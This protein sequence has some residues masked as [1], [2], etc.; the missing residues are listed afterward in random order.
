MSDARSIL[1]LGI[2][3]G[4]TKTYGVVLDGADK[5]VAR[6]SSP[7]Q[8]SA[9]GVQASV[10]GVARALAVELGIDITGFASVGIGIPG[11]V[12]TCTGEVVSAVNLG[13]DRMP[14]A[15]AMA[16]VFQVPVCID[17]DMKVALRGAGLL[18][19]TDSLVY[20]NIG[21]GVASAAME[22]GRVVRGTENIAGEIGHIIYEPGGPLCLCGQQGCLE[23]VLGGR[24]LVPR[25]AEAGVE[26]A[27]L[28][29]MPKH[30]EYARCVGALAW[31]ISVLYLMYDPSVIALGGGVVGAASWL[32]EALSAE[33]TTRAARAMFPD[34]KLIE[35]RLRFPSTTDRAEVGAI[36][37][38]LVGRD[39]ADSTK[40]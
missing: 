39:S 21:T 24:Y 16:P 28:G 37:A 3:V 14:L 30:P 40:G 1:N 36:G 29:A 8:K 2:D 11:M 18:L 20:L 9:A 12:D 15:A 25:L 10:T 27:G 31:A 26:W 22:R 13:F 38:A 7:T 23:A 4:G 33:L 34:F 6:G 17:N 32:P 35:S 5:V 19:G